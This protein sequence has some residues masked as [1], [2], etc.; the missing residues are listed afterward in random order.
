MLKPAAPP[1]R[2]V[3][4]E[5]QH[6]QRYR[7]RAAG[8]QRRARRPDAVPDRRRLPY[9]LRAPP[10]HAAGADDVRRGGARDTRRQR[11]ARTAM[12]A[13]PTA[14]LAHG[15]CRRPTGPRAARCGVGAGAF[16]RPNR[17]G[18]RGVRLELES[19]VRRPC[20]PGLPA[21]PVPPS[22]SHAARRTRARRSGKP[23][24]PYMARF[25]VFSLWI[26]PSAGLVFQG[27]SNVVRTAPRAAAD[28]GGEASEMHTGR[29]GEHPVQVLVAI[30]AQQP[31]QALRHGQGLRERRGILE[32]LGGEI[33]LGRGQRVGV[34]HQQARDPRPGGRPPRD[35]MRAGGARS[36]DARQ[37]RL[38]FY[39]PPP[40]RPG[41]HDARATAQASSH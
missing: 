14:S 15:R 8:A 36:G 5:R 31:V 1:Q 2:P 21:L 32:Q 24:R 27:V 11:R 10:H 13:R 37:T 35:G 28:A 40:P 3:L 38:R 41:A 9:P 39:F 16:A 22:R 34:G 19:R 30:A 17:V 23:A 12:P 18:P 6:W 20:K 4:V 29:V 26:R 33:A 7:R 25:S